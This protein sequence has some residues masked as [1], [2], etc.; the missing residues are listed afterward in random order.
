MNE[1]GKVKDWHDP[2]DED[3][4]QNGNVALD[5]GCKQPRNRKPYRRVVVRDNGVGHRVNPVL[6]FE[7]Y[8]DGTVAMR[9]K[10]RKQR[11]YTTASILYSR[12]MLQAA[13]A[14]LAAK[15]KARSERKKARKERR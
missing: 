3:C 2:R 1:I 5:C 12:L 8:P 13:Q 7:I 14:H 10:K 6:V 9:E 4:P 11:F 15:R